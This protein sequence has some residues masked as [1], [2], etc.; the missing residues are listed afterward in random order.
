MVIMMVTIAIVNSFSLTSFSKQ[1]STL[2]DRRKTGAKTAEKRRKR[3]SNRKPVPQDDNPCENEKCLTAHSG[4]HQS[5]LSNPVQK[6][7]TTKLII[8]PLYL[9]VHL[10]Y[11]CWQS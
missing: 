9:F 7:L 4:P 3:L 5:T 6:V 10:S 11:P 2:N 1:E 8:D